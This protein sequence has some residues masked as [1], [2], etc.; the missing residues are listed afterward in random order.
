MQSAQAAQ[1]GPSLTFITKPITREQVRAI[2]FY[3]WCGGIGAAAAA[4]N[5]NS[6]L[7]EGT[8]IIRTVKHWRCWFCWAPICRPSCRFSRDPVTSSCHSPLRPPPKTHISHIINCNSP[9]SAADES[10]LDPFYEE[11]E[12]VI[13]NE[14]S[15]KF[16]VGDFSAKLRKATEEKHRIGRFGLGDRSENGNRLA[17]LGERSRGTRMMCRRVSRRLKNVVNCTARLLIPS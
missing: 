14:K 6:R 3:E 5:M 17:G 9:T 4:R 2:I 13:R 12:E 15:Y 1:V 10:E 11:L 8:T 16:V 7:R